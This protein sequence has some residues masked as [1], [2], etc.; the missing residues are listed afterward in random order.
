MCA[1]T[2]DSLQ[3]WIR[4]ACRGEA[5]NAKP[6]N[7]MPGRDFSDTNV[8]DFLRSAD[9][10]APILARTS[11]LGVG[12]AIL[13]AVDATQ[14][15]V[16]QNTNLG[17]ILLLAPLAAVPPNVSLD[18]G[19]EP[20]LQSL[21]IEDAELAYRAIALAAPGGLGNAS[22]QDVAARPTE[23]L[24]SCMKLAADR[25]LIAAQ[26]A[27]GFQQVLVD[28]LGLLATADAWTACREKRIAWMAVSLI[29]QHGDSLIA[30]KNGSQVNDETQRRAQGVLQ[31]GW[32]FKQGSQRFYDEFDGW[33]RDDEHRRNPGTTA[34]LIAAILFAAQRSEMISIDET[35]GAIEFSG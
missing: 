3:R 26:Y 21:T 35:D 25:D 24:R 29:A 19:V 10:I 22:Q 31:T 4:N 34:D 30:R 18:A 23:N 8:D 16:G 9:I 33:L 17:I 15:R 20:V 32:P 6:G 14:Q 11:E 7:V 2:P 1:A 12:A 27:N 5:L 28:G 13:Q